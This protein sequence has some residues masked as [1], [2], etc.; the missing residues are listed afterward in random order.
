MFIEEIRIRVIEKMDTTLC[1]VTR[2][3]SF[4]KKTNHPCT[5]IF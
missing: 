1:V 3:N 5:S 4:M 2:E